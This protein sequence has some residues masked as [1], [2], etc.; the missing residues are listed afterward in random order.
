MGQ[1]LTT[2]Y[3]S[4]QRTIAREALEE[5]DGGCCTAGARC[6]IGT[7]LERI[8]ASTKLTQDVHP[9]ADRTPP[10]GN[11][12]GRP[13]RMPDPNR[14]S[15]AQ[16]SY[17]TSLLA[18]LEGQPEGSQACT[19]HRMV[20]A[21]L[22][23]RTE[24]NRHMSKRIASDVI[25]KLKP[26]AEALPRPANNHVRRP[27]TSTHPQVTEGMYEMDASVYRV[28]TSRAGRLYALLLVVKD[29]S[30]S[31]DYAPGVIDR[32]RPEHRMTVERAAQLSVEYHFCVRCAK[33]L[34]KD[35]SIAQGMGDWCASRV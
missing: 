25:G 33:E 24:Q 28:R 15:D 30:G 13:S 5:H 11:G 20:S 21:D 6:E 29:G 9:D 3:T 27:V 4:F 12:N 16:M 19:W 35:S 10:R 32:L 34:T 8:A 1:T 14:A 2:G 23:Q 31:F 17:I 22:A 7:G 18:R 26:L